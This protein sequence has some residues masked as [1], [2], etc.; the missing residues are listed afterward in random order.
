VV[1]AFTVG[2]WLVRRAFTWSRRL[3]IPYAQT[4]VVL[5]VVLLSAA[6]TQA[7]HVHLVLGAFVAGILIAR[8]PDRDRSAREGIQNVGMAFFIPY[9][10]AYTGLKVDLGTLRGSAILVGVAA[11]VVACVGKLL[12]AGLGAR[13][14]GMPWRQS[15]A[16]GAGRNARGAM[17]LVIA[18]IGLSIGVLTL[19]MYSIVV[20]VAVFTTLMAGPLLKALLGREDAPTTMSELRDA[21]E[22][23]V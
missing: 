5:V 15:V 8:S 4:T 21:R 16:V 2:Q 20:L 11:L 18:A 3:R 9:F 10:F 12:G 1:F 13:L 22:V 19:P 17:E 14:G 7:I 6:I 23:A